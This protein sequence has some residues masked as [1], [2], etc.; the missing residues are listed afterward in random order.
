MRYIA[1]CSLAICLFF[2]LTSSACEQFQA[3]V[4]R[5]TQLKRAG[6]TAKQ[7]NRWQ[8]Q[9][10]LYAQ[11]YR[12]CLRDQP[13]MQRA[14]GKGS[15]K[16][17]KPD[18]QKPRQVDHDHPVVQKLL[19]TCNFWINTYNL[20]PSPEN[21]TYRDS[22]CRSLDDALRHPPAPIDN[23]S[24]QRPLKECIKPGNLLDDDV[25]DCMAGIREPDWQ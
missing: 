4:E 7:M 18:V 11:R 21:K 14:T 13:T 2:P 20:D 15:G 25:R 22:A 12:E 8:A 3:K 24:N 17:N 6:G 5:Y 19:G 1:L 10:K 16:R 23:S 9:R